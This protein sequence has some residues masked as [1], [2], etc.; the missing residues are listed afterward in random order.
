MK[1][2]AEKY[3]GE[4]H[5][6][7]DGILDPIFREK[8]KP[9]FYHYF[10]TNVTT[11]EGLRN[12]FLWNAV[13]T[14]LLGIKGKEVLD[15]GCGTGLRLICLALLGSKRAVG[16]DISE[17]MIGCAQI[18]LC[19]F[20]RLD[21][22]VRRGD[23]L[24]TDCCPSSFD[25][26]IL[27]EA[28]SHIRDSQLLLDKIYHVLRPGGSL[29]ISDGNND[30][31]LS[32]RIRSRMAWR[33]AEYGPIDANEAEYG[34]E[35]D[36]LSYFEARMKIIKEHYPSLDDRTLKL[37]ARKTQG[38]W[39]EEIA[40]ASDEF[41]TTGKICQKGSFR[42]RNPYNGEFPELGFNPLSL[43]RHL[44]RRGFHVQF[45]PTPWAYVGIPPGSSRTIH[46]AHR[47]AS[48]ILKVCPKFLLPF[49][50]P[51]FNILAIKE[52]T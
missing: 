9:L 28:I 41:V 50:S 38:M 34:R 24:L 49:L 37:V 52:S 7:E 43:S 42:W 25:V 14:E 5:K 29:Y 15:I 32:T 12:Y 16:I 20:P 11:K 18:L 40:K 30:L 39:G 1:I 31:F 10:R 13:I 46:I 51:F 35:I 4:I 17:E 22:E 8:M 2:N 21:I 6:F 27:I 47:V 19:E 3:Y 36:R 45:V 44:R 23:F 48:P 26:V 33:R